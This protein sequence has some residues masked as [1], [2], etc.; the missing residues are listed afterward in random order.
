MYF[1]QKDGVRNEGGFWQ[2]ED[3]H[4]KGTFCHNYDLSW[5]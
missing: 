3:F 5:N 2:K 4:S 1:T